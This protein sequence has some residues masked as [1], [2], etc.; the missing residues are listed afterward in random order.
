MPTS[1]IRLADAIVTVMKP[2]ETSDPVVRDSVCEG[3]GLPVGIRG[4][5]LLL[6]SLPS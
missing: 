5:W 6:R 1:Q 2:P 4:R 3:L